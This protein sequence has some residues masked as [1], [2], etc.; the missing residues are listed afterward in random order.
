MADFATQY[1][2]TT[3]PFIYF[4]FVSQI[5]QS[6]ANNQEVTWYGLVAVICGTLGH[7]LLVC[8]TYIW[9]DMGFQ[10]IIISTGI[11]FFLRFLV[12]FSLVT[13]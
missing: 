6:F 10:G 7:A 9:L 12:T 11:M 5:Y 2:H 4:F 1:V 13:F 3:I 8:V